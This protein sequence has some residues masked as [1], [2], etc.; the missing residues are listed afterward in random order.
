MGNVRRKRR[1]ILPIRQDQRSTEAQGIE[2]K[3]HFLTDNR[4]RPNYA[5]LD[6]THRL[7]VVGGE[8]RESTGLLIRWGKIR[9]ADDC[10]QIQ[11]KYKP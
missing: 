11:L 8:N 2:L 1:G 4:E 3:R 10:A 7:D 5:A 9:M 6:Y